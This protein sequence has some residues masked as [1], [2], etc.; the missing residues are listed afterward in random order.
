MW[1]VVLTGA[2]WHFFLTSEGYVDYVD[3]L[4]L[5]HQT[6]AAAGENVY[7]PA[8]R[9]ARHTR[10]HSMDQY[11]TT[12]R[13]DARGPS[14]T[15]ARSAVSTASILAICGMSWWVLRRRFGLTPLLAAVG[16]L[17]WLVT[18]GSV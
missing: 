14:V 12:S 17:P 13:M 1:S 9:V 15:F 7:N 18:E 10:F 16:S 8:Y 11:S 6:Q 4:V 3:G 2:I 5:F